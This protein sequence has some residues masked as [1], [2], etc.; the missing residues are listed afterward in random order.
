MV[1]TWFRA[2]VAFLEYK[3]KWW[4]KQYERE[5]MGKNKKPNE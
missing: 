2:I 3:T 1:G 5:V 4:E